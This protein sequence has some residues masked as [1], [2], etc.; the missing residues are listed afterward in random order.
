MLPKAGPQCARRLVSIEDQTTTDFVVQITD[1][2]HNHDEINTNGWK[3][4]ITER[5]IALYNS[6]NDFTAKKIHEIFKAEKMDSLPTVSQIQSRIS[7]HWQP[8]KAQ[9]EAENENA[10]ANNVDIITVGEVIQWAGTKPFRPEMDDDSPFVIDIRASNYSDKEKYFQYIVSTK[11]LLRNAANYSTICVDATYKVLL[12][13]YPLLTMGSIDL[14]RRFHMIAA[15]VCV[16]ENTK[17]FE[18]FY[19]SAHIV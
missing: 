14:N 11:R 17:D 1:A 18:F 7:Y 2:E 6:N 15:A 8:G 5:I 10:V 3:P 4:A 12:H 19:F 16:T 9:T 13:G